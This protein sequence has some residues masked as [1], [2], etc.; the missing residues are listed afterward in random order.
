MVRVTAPALSL[1]ASGTIGKTVTYAKWKGRNYARQRVIPTNP[2]SASQSGLRAMF[3]FLSQQWDGMADADKEDYDAE[4]ESRQL[5]AFNVFM[6][7]NMDR[8]QLND[9]PSQASPPPEA[10]TPLTITTMTLTGG[11]GH[12]QVDLTP[13]AATDIWGFIICRSTAD[14]TAPSW[15]NAVAVIAAD[16]ANKVEYVDSPLDAGTYHYRA[17]AFC[18]DGIVGTYIA[19][20]TE[21]AT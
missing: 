13:S 5:S 18:D 15:T 1:D 3:K 14:I 11:D 6:S 9:G 21:A 2:K 16:G 20:D 8:W 10:A 12:V 4:A 7:K 19:D 17:A